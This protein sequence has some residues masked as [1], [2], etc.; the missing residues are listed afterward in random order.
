MSSAWLTVNDCRAVPVVAEQANLGDES[1]NVV[2][3]CNV[4]G[5]VG[6]L[7]CWHSLFTSHTKLVSSFFAVFYSSGDYM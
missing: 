7:F 3:T 6:A 4:R 2:D 5:A 1:Q